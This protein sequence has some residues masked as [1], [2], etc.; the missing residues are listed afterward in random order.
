MA[1]ETFVNQNKT[2]LENSSNTP[3]HLTSRDLAAL[4]LLSV[5]FWQ[6]NVPVDG[7]CQQEKTTP[8]NTEEITNP[9]PFDQLYAQLKSQ[10]PKH[11]AKN[12]TPHI[13][14]VCILHLANEKVQN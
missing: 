9:Y 4:T 12:L 11:M 14:F 8:K 10:L 2:L 1:S 3:L 13:G 5:F 6:E 7:E